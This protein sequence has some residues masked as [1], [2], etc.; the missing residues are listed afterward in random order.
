[1]PAARQL[2]AWLAGAVAAALMLAGCNSAPPQPQ[3]APAL[4][5][6]TGPDGQHGYLF[7]TVHSLP[8]GYS[9]RSPALD[10]AFAASDELVVE[11]DLAAQGSAVGAIF[12]QLSRSPGL[13]PLTRR[14]PPAQRDV[15]RKALAG[16]GLS[17]ADFDGVE[18]WAAAIALSQAYEGSDGEGVDLAL[19]KQAKGKRIVALE[20]AEKQLRLFDALPEAD[21]RE[22]L[23]AVAS[24]ALEGEQL[25]DARLNDWLTGNV[26]ALAQE[27]HQGLLA[28][29]ELREV[30]LTRRNLD[31]AARISA[32]LARGDRVFV[33][34]GAAHMVGPQGLAALLAGR[35]YKVTRIQ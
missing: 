10:R 32:E 35:G 15:L 28:D 17:D 34:V 13:P 18:S 20:G 9:W 3:P 22:L 21:Q 33:A 7:G 12:A 6:I 26:T 11:V 31:W 2:R 14:L 19:L 25:G 5:E 8:S 27:T 4:W 24:E 30:L 16:K 23:A 1:M 29:P